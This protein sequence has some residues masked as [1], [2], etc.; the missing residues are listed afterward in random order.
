MPSLFA[1]LHF[2]TQPHTKLPAKDL[3][4]SLL[5]FRAIAFAKWKKLN[6]GYGAGQPATVCCVANIL[7]VTGLK[8]DHNEAFNKF[9]LR[10]F[11]ITVPFFCFWVLFFLSWQHLVLNSNQRLQPKYEKKSEERWCRTKVIIWFWKIVD[12]G[13]FGDLFLDFFISSFCLFLAFSNLCACKTTAPTR[14]R[15]AIFSSR[16]HFGKPVH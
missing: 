10:W 8:S 1:L 13:V 9:F 12:I 16:W 6:K 11:K 5:Y 15:Q 14:V 4:Q 3:M 2:N 7:N